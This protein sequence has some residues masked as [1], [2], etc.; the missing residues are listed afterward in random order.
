MSKN[1]KNEALRET[2][3][4]IQCVLQPKEHISPDYFENS[5]QKQSHPIQDDDVPPYYDETAYSV[6]TVRIGGGHL[7]TVLKMTP[8]QLPCPQELSQPTELPLQRESISLMDL[9]WS[10][11]ATT[12]F[13]HAIVML[14]ASCLS[15]YLYFLW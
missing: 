3:H 10:S 2:L 11:S 8:E 15:S 6:D 9:S 5:I 13:S 7:N 12:V 4:R 14:S 1:T